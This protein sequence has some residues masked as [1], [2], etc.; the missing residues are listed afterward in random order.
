[1]ISTSMER[2]PSARQLEPGQQWCIHTFNNI[3]LH[4]VSGDGFAFL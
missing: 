2:D 3:Q 1:M 4:R